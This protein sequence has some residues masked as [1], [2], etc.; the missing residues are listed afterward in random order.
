MAENSENVKG[1]RVPSIVAYDAD[2]CA[3]SRLKRHD[4]AF[5]G[6]TRFLRLL[7]VIRYA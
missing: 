7:F 4:G 3:L 2:I 6:Q 1:A 5:F